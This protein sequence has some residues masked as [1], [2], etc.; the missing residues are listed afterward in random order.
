MYRLNVQ[1]VPAILARSLCG[2][3]KCSKSLDMH[4]LQRFLDVLIEQN[5]QILTVLYISKF[6]LKLFMMRA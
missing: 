5:K 3:I 6:F 4:N 1:A 2:T